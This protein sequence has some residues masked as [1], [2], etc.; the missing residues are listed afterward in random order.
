MTRE[1]H[2]RNSSTFVAKAE[3]QLSYF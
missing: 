2:V 3:L 1:I